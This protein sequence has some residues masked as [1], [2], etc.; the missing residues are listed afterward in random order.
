[1]QWPQDHKGKENSTFLTNENR[2]LKFIVSPEYSGSSIPVFSQ[3]KPYQIWDFHE[4]SIIP[5]KK[6]KIERKMYKIETLS[7]CYIK[8]IFDQELNDHKKLQRKKQILRNDLS[9]KGDLVSD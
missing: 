2:Q 9:K 8:K 7:K 4:L 1:M 6:K 5:K 3:F